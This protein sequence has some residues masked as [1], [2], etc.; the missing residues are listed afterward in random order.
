M[1]LP[2][3][4]RPNREGGR[5]GTYTCAHFQTCNHSHV[6]VHRFPTCHFLHDDLRHGHAGC[7]V[8][9]DQIHDLLSAVGNLEE[10]F[11]IGV[12]HPHI[13]D[14]NANLQTSWKGEGNKGKGGLR[15]GKRSREE[16]KTMKSTTSPT[17]RQKKV[18]K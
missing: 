13:V 11:G 7:D 17:D 14:Q 4:L 2:T 5:G 1:L 6:L 12:T 15:K 10:V 3:I 16:K 8:Q 18:V 9:I